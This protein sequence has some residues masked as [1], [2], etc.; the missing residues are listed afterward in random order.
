[1]NVAEHAPATLYQLLAEALPTPHVIVPCGPTTSPL[2][3]ASHVIGVLVA[4]TG[5]ETVCILDDVAYAVFVDADVVPT[6]NERVEVGAVVKLIAACMIDEVAFNGFV[7]EHKTVVVA[8]PIEAR[9]ASILVAT[10]V[11]LSNPS[12]PT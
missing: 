8:L 1:M 11:P 7:T 3:D 5:T 9:A 6:T 2:M 10:E 12:A 4:D